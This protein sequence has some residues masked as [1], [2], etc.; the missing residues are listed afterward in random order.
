MRDTR[1]LHPLDVADDPDCWLRRWHARQ[2]HTRAA[3]AIR[4]SVDPLRMFGDRPTTRERGE[5]G[6]R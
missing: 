2:C 3:G 4:R 6:E 5:R 1:E